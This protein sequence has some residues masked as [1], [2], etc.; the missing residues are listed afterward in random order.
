MAITLTRPAYC[1]CIVSA[2]PLLPRPPPR[3]AF[4]MRPLLKTFT[5]P[6]SESQV[7]SGQDC[8]NSCIAVTTLNYGLLAASYSAALTAGTSVTGF[9]ACVALCPRRFK[10]QRWHCT[11]NHSH[12]AHTQTESPHTHARTLRLNREPEG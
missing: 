3:P 4:G 5:F 8:N 1:C 9:N 12:T 10:R 7:S 6:L 11:D 2:S